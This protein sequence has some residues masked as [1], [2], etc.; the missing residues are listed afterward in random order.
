MKNLARFLVIAAVAALA[1]PAMGS[2]APT[3]TRGVVVQRDAR[4]GVVVVATKS[5]N[6]Q[7]LKLAKPNRLAMGSLVRVNGKRISVVGHARKAKIRGIVVRRSHHK[8]ALAGNGS[9]LAVASASPPVAGQEITTTVQVTP[10]RLSDDDGEVEVE[11]EDHTGT[12]K[13]NGTVLGQTATTL[14]LSFNGFPA[15]LPIAIGSVVIPTLAPNTPVQVRVTLGPDPANPAAIVVT[16]VSL[17][18]GGGEHGDDDDHDL[19]IEAEGHVTLITEAG[20]AG[21][22]AGSI[23]IAG[24]HGAV[25]FIIPAGFGAT[26]VVVGDEVEAKGTAGATPA[27][28]PTL[29]RLE[30]DEHGTAN[31]GQSE[32]GSHSDGAH[33]DD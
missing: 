13:L 27:D 11:D 1:A 30:I 6:L 9:V 25:T 31:D 12:I 10:T 32:D 14:L 21:G 20:P 26:G 17:R 3:G 15:G 16:L 23:T 2:A 24:E 33:G 4:A 8:F 7:R 22:A 28:L 19:R 5:G 18:V 29:V